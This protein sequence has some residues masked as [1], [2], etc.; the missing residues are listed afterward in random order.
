MFNI[1][2]LLHFHLTFIGHA[3]PLHWLQGQHVAMTCTDSARGQDA[4]LGGGS[5]P[6]I[7][8]Q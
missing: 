5:V 1:F 8:Q 2:D 3:P 4:M 6:G 7:S